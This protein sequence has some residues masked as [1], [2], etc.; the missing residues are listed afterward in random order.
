MILIIGA[1]SRIGGHL[2]E[3]FRE[4]HIRVVG[5]YCHNHRAGLCRFDLTHMKLGDLE[6]PKP[7]HVIISAAL[8]PRPEL[9]QKSPEAAREINVE[10][11]NALIEYCF[12]NNIVPYYFSTDNVF[13]GKKGHYT[14]H[15]ETNPLNLYGRMK[16]EIEECLLGA[17]RPW[18][19]MRMG[20]V[21]GIKNDDTLFPETL[22]KL[23]SGEKFLCATDQV[24]TP[25]YAD[26]LYAFVRDSICNDYAGIYHLGSMKPTTRY[27][28]AQQISTYFNINPQNITP[29]KINEIGLSEK[30]PL[31]IDLNIDKY[32][33]LTG[34]SE[35]NTAYFIQQL[36]RHRMLPGPS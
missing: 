17:D 32:K 20:K 4:N 13:D 36:S 6:I 18:V 35:K 26:D 33:A 14:E 24:F 5:T 10:K 7:T 23:R 34:A 21:F 15:D 3:K 12:E 22:G 2:Y 16:C 8:N 29:C 11:T 27:E 19:L 31:Q 9:S 1:S 28:I 25:L 30:R